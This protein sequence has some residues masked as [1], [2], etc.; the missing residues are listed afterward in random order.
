MN[1]EKESV[2]SDVL[3]VQSQT[4]DMLME[5]PKVFVYGAGG[6]G[7]CIS[8]L[9][10][11]KGIEIDGFIDSNSSRS[12]EVVDGITIYRVDE[13]NLVNSVVIVA[14]MFYWEVLPKLAFAINKLDK[15]LFYFH[16]VEDPSTFFLTPSYADSCNH[17]VSILADDQSREVVRSLLSYRA[18]LDKTYIDRINTSPQYFCELP[19]HIDYSNFYDIGAFTGDTLDALDQ[20]NITPKQ[21]VCFEPD[22]NNFEV[23]ERK[24]SSAKVSLQ[25]VAVGNEEGV[26]RFEPTTLGYSSKVADSGSV[27][28]KQIMLDKFCGGDIAPPTFLKIDV[29]GSDLDVLK[30]AINVIS[31]QRPTIAVSIYHNPAHLHAIPTWINENLTDYDLF[32]RHHRDSIYETICYAVPKERVNE[33]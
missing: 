17:L 15:L 28:V 22:E 9:L 5:A 19:A 33:S 13:L 16:Y 30:G 25:N 6:A 20:N 4:F 1:V 2:T 32:I 8:G 26:I 11:N 27:T 23:L 14:T 7:K 3:H 18:T 12:G 21:M 31:R 29:E 24:Y 10:K